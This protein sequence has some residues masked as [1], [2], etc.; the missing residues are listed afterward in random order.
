[1]RAILF[2]LFSSF[3]ILVS[4]NNK[5]SSP[6]NDIQGEIE[7]KDSV[8]DFGTVDLKNPIDSFDFKFKNTG[9]QVIAVLQAKTSCHC[10]EVKYPKEPIRSGEESYIRVIYNGT[11]RSPEYFNKSVRVYTT[12]SFHPKLLRIRGKLK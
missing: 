5:K 12:A 10:T 3:L 11:G 4:C 7:W 8:H 9:N 1:M 6:S 2:V